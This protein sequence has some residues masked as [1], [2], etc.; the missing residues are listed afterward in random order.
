MRVLGIWRTCLQVG[1]LGAKFDGMIR[2][3]PQIKLTTRDED[4]PFILERTHFL[5]R[6]C[7]PMTRN[8]TQG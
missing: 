7:S 2:L 1:I 5:E 6:L 8:K 3:L 4:L